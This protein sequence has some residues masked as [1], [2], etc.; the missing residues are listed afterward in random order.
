[1]ENVRVFVDESSHSSCTEL[2]GEP[3]GFTRTRTSRK[4]RAYS[5][6]H[7]NWYWSILKNL[8]MRIRFKVHLPHGRDQYCLTIMWSSGHKQKHASTQVPSMPGKDEWKQ[9]CNYKMGRS[10]GRIRNVSFLQWIDGNRWRSHWI[11]VEY[12]HRICVIADSSRN[13]KWCAKT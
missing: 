2:V 3:G 11:R 4:F 10:S 5:I 1:M 12:F 13:P 7:R 6:S 8:W 9:R